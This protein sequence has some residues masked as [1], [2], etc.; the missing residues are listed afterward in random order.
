VRAP[1]CVFSSGEAVERAGCDGDAAASF[2]HAVVPV[3]APSAAVAGLYGD[4]RGYRKFCCCA[5]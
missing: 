4:W 5:E 3:G 2:A 1:G